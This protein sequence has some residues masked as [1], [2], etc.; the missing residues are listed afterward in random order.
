MAD[1]IIREATLDDA[2]RILIYNELIINETDNGILRGPGENLTL[3]E[4]QTYLAAS[5]ASD[6]SVLLIAVLHTGE[7]IGISGLQ[8]GSRKATRHTGGVGI[9]INRERRDQGIGTAL[10]Q[11]V[12]EWAKKSNIIKRIELEVMTHNQRAIHVYEKLGFQME[13]KHL[14]ALYKEGRYI[15]IYLMGL[16]LFDY[17]AR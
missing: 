14:A 4:E 9:S 7:V 2:E 15:D 16:L 8:G 12:I 3:E 5:I 17:P 6:N 11:Q 10:L 1:Y 13:G